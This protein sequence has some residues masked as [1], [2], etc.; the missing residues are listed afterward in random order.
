MKVVFASAG[1]ATRGLTAFHDSGRRCPRGMTRSTKSAWIA[2]I[3]ARM[4]IDGLP[5]VG[6]KLHD[7]PAEQ[8][9]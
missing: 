2:R 8:G 1:T 6:Q 7:Q 3:A 9:S 4:R 5:R